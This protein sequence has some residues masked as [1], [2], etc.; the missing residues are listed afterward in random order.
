MA[1]LETR[2]E[3]KASRISW[4][5]EPRVFYS[6]LLFSHHT[7]LLSIRFWS[8]VLVCLLFLFYLWSMFVFDLHVSIYSI[9]LSPIYE[10]YLLPFF[11][12]CYYLPSSGSFFLFHCTLSQSKVVYWVWTMNE[13]I[14]NEL[15]TVLSQSI[16]YITAHWVR[17]VS[18]SN[19]N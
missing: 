14:S 8:Q 3:S 2:R 19:Q 17:I 1:G 18:D 5:S 4:S 7:M 10:Y 6:S 9:L 16:S 11:F 13:L 12:L 15:M